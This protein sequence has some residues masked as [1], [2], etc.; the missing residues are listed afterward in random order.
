MNKSIG[1][2]FYQGFFSQILMIHRTAG[3]GRGSSF[4]PLYHF[5]PLT[6]IAMFIYNFV[7]EMTLHVRWLSRI[8]N[9]HACV[10]QTANRWDLPPYQVTILLTDWWCNVCLFNWWIHTRFL[11]Q[12]FDIGNQSIWTRMDYHSCITS[13]PTN[14]MR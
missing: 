12:R 3:K 5:H 2:F 9:R 13:E 1:S 4:V 8:F 11:L 10:Y 6:N 14:Q 7:C